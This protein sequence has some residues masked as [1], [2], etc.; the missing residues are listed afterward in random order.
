MRLF[1][2]RKIGWGKN[3]TVVDES[4][5]YIIASLSNAKHPCAQGE[6]SNQREGFRKTAPDKVNVGN[7]H[8]LILGFFLP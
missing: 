4:I 7:F 1:E 2:I 8:W 6:L 3:E 5:T